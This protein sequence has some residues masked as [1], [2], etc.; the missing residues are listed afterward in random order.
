MIEF[1]RGWKR[2]NNCGQLGL[3]D[4]GKEVILMGWVHSRRDLGNLIFIDL[5]DREGITQIVF[6]PQVDKKAHNKAK[7]LRNEYVI[8]IKGEVAPRLEGQENPKLKTGEIEVRAKEIKILNTSHL[9]PF[10]IDG[11]VDGS[12]NLRLRYRYLEMR[13]H[14]VMSIFK[15]RHKMASFIRRYLDGKGFIEVETPFLT[16]ST[17]EGARDYLVPSR[18]NKGKFY[19]LPQSP[20]LFKQILMVA[21]FDKY[22]QIV[23]CFRDEDL[24]ADRQPEFTQVD[25]EMS[26]VDEDDIMTLFDN[27]MK[28]LFMEILHYEISTP[29]PRLD[30]NEAMNR[31][32]SDKP[33]TRFGME[34]NDITELCKKTGFK[35]FQ[36]VIHKGG[37]VKAIVVK[38]SKL[39]RKELDSLSEEARQY[40]AKGIFWAKITGDDWQSPIKKYIDTKI[41]MD[42]NRLMEAEEGD[43]IIMIADK[44]ETANKVLGTIRMS[45]AQRLGIIKDGIYSPAW[46]KGFPLFQYNQEQERIESVHHPFTSPVEEDIG[47]LEKEPTKVRAKA[48]DLVLN[49]EEIGGG[50]VRIHMIELQKKI[51]KILEIS[52]D[53]AERRFGFFIEAL[54]YGAPPHG[55]MAL[56]FDRLVAIMAG[57]S[58]IREVIPFPKS[59]SATCPLT[60]APSEVDPEQLKEL[61]IKIEWGRGGE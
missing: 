6:D 54:K 55:G 2:T 53:E 23:R 27:M 17:P 52:E 58:S 10:Q 21:G 31:F 18:I 7:D 47:L 12:E 49:G 33:D 20:Q 56:G 34:L 59:T 15:L 45:I 39:S 22:Y 26:F 14:E 61:S 25:V 41:K 32:G 1:I 24:R 4:T 29:I 36:D 48:Y 57:K 8:A 60:G 5:R 44:R 11:A 50:S 51:F 38:N 13:R 43:I 16:K 30:Y 46:I 19:A 42:I 37:T 35:I 28:E 40:G 3:K 9:P